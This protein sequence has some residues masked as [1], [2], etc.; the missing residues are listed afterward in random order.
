[1]YFLTFFLN[2]LKHLWDITWFYPET[3]A[4][5]CLPNKDI[6]LHNHSAIV[7]SNKINSNI[8]I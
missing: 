4:Y 7:V 1:M 5:A 3:V 2:I 6:I 8:L